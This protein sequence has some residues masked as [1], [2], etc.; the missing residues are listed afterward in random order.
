MVEF[1][2]CYLLSINEN[3]YE[4]Y[5]CEITEIA[6]R[7]ISNFDISKGIFLH[8]FNSAWKQEYSHIIGK[9][10]HEDK[11][12]GLRIAEEDRRAVR[13]YIR[14]ADQLGMDCASEELYMKLS[15]AMAL[16]TERV[17]ELA[18]L[19]TLNVCG[20]NY[21]SDDGDEQSLWDQL[22]GNASVSHRIETAEEIK[23]ILERIEKAFNSLQVRQRPIVS[24][25]IT[26]KICSLLTET[27]VGQ[28]SFI[29]D[30]VITEWIKRGTVPTQRD[31][32]KK[33]GRDEASVSRTLND[34]LKKLKKVG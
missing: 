8:Y 3:E 34:F 15:E 25:M 32:A 20:D 16:P 11:Y 6:T 1:L 26:I 10:I 29:S 27:R 17:K 31:I 5:G 12:R 33:Y 18:K 13:K 24:D 2:Y 4:P 28:F 9:K 19:S 23:A 22:P 21:K 30:S 7:C 14:L